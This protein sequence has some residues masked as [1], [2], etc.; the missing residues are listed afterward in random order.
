MLIPISNIIFLMKTL[1][2]LFC[3]EKAVQKMSGFFLPYSSLMTVF[4]SFFTLK[5][6]SLSEQTNWTYFCLMKTCRFVYV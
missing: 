3:K 4:F 6:E 2:K 1:K 5:M